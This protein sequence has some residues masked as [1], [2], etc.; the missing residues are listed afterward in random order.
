M[1]RRTVLSRPSRVPAP[2]HHDVQLAQA[3]PKASRLGPDTPLSAIDGIGPK[4][5]AA[6]AA[7]NIR[8]VEDALLHLPSRYQDWRHRT[9]PADLRPGMTAV[10]EGELASVAE[11]P[12]RGSFW[13]RL[14]IASL[15]VSSTET[16]RLVWFNLPAYMRGR[17]PAGE[18]VL[19]H[20]RVTEAP[21]GG[22]E[23]AHPELM[24]LT[25]GEPPPIR[26]VYRLPREIG[27]RLFASIIAHALREVG[28]RIVAAVPPEMRSATSYAPVGDALRDLHS[29]PA[30]SDIAALQAGASDAH[31][32]LAFDELFAFELALAI[33][34][35]R[36]RRRAGLKL[37][38]DQSLTARMLSA[39][40]FELTDA[41][42]RAIDEI[43]ADLAAPGQMNRMLLGDVGSGK[44]LVAF[45]AALRAVESETQAVMMAPTEILAEQHFRS[46][47]NICGKLD[48]P[49]ALLTASITPAERSATLRGLET[50][51]IA[52]AFGTHALIQQRVRVRKLGLG[53]IDEQHRFGV[54]DRARLKSLGPAANLLMMTATPIPR[55]LAMNLFANLDVSVLDEMP[56]GRT[57]VETELFDEEQLGAVDAIVKREIDAKHRAYYVLPRIDADDEEDLRS[58][59]ATATRLRKGALKGARIAVVHGRMR[60]EEKH[61]VMKDFRDGAIDVLVATTVIE[62]GIDVAAATL[63]VV[64]AAERY[65]LAQLHQLRGR[66]GR[67]EV[68]SRCIL[69]AS[70]DADPNAR[71]RLD[72]M[73]RCRNGSEVAE[74]DLRLRGPGDLLGSRQTGALPLRF[75]DFI[76]DA[77]MI[78]HARGLAE[79][80]LRR[81]PHLE[82]PQSAG[83]RA[84]VQRMLAYGFSLADVG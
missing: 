2:P 84:S 15:I 40:P 42:R 12:M 23:I 54:F 39:I 26:P 31:A 19:V 1:A 77:S 25:S 48:V 29:P 75:G 22:L 11:K 37:C 18:R 58:V 74:E 83:A 45:W 70:S 79:E 56:V 35:E 55:S 27:Q 17:L 65:G 62:V 66:V 51:R 50:G 21:Q 67:G 10:V 82:S 57:P 9:A 72:V 46:F 59:N 13:R 76:R 24:T 33:D 78:E 80:W 64:F 47:R 28:A 63:I 61:R 7:K 53:I 60:G 14:V 8:T 43:G 41:Q 20:G 71:E 38:A 32:A 52:I 3:P 4:R 30:Q 73:V 68:A 81:D 6:L 69:I 44:T 34:R 36:S 49:A 5:T 16:I